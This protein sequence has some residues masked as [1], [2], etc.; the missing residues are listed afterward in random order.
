MPQTNPRWFGVISPEYDMGGGGFYEPPEPGCDWVPVFTTSKRRAIILAVRTWRR[1]ER[2]PIGNKAR[3]SDHY[4][5]L[6]QRYVPPFKGMRAEPLLPCPHGREWCRECP[7]CVAEAWD[8]IG[9]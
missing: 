3:E 8:E 1:R 4:F 9:F 5:R 2:L 6:D 7:D